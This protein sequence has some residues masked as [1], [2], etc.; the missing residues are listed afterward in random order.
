MNVD[1]FYIR[2]PEELSLRLRLVFGAYG[3]TLYGIFVQNMNNY[4]SSEHASH[5][6]KGVAYMGPDLS[7]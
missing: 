5:V 1:A 6:A 4:S 3:I 7:R 2:E